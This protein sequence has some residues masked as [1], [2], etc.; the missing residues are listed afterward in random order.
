[1]LLAKARRYA[2]NDI[3]VYIGFKEVSLKATQSN[4]V[5]NSFM[6]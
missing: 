2:S 6:D 3:K 4:V 1:M 5:E